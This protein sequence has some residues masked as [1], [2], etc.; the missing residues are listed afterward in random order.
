MNG[1]P[2]H[3]SCKSEGGGRGKGKRLL[4]FVFSAGGGREIILTYCHWLGSSHTEAARAGKRED[5]GGRESIIIYYYYY[6]YYYYSTISSGG[7]GGLPS[8]I[9]NGWEAATSKMQGRGEG[10]RAGG[11]A[12][13]LCFYP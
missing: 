13:Q 2:P 12:V 11:N 10:R 3:R 1:K 4:V 6:H 8:L 9:A 7:G 5:A